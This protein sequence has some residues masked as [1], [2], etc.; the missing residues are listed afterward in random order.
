MLVSR[1]DTAIRQRSDGDDFAGPLLYEHVLTR[2]L[3]ACHDCPLLEPAVSG[4]GDN[5]PARLDG[6][7]HLDR[8]RVSRQR[9]R[10]QIAVG[11]AARDR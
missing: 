5:G 9:K 3:R 6:N 1:H 4:P 7:R 2:C 10:S 8:A 11:S